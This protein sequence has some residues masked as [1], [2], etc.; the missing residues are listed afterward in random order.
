LVKPGKYCRDIILFPESIGSE[1]AFAFATGRE[2]KGADIIREG[3]EMFENGEYLKFIRAKP[4]SIED[5]CFGWELVD[6]FFGDECFEELMSVVGDFSEA[7][8]ELGVIGKEV[9]KD[10]F[11]VIIFAGTDE[12]SGKALS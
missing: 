7:E 3:L 6:T 2:V 4:M 5:T 9:F 11:T 10:L 8:V 1:L 12:F